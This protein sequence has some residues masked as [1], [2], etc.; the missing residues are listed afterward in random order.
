MRKTL[1]YFHADRL[2]YAVVGTPNRVEYDQGFFVAEPQ[3]NLVLQIAPGI[4]MVG[5]AGYRVV[6]AANGAEDQ[7]RGLTGSFSIRFGGGK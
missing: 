2:N 4:A 3:V 7:I 6:A 5:G 1:E